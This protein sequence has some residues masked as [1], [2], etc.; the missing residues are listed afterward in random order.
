MLYIVTPLSRVENLESI[1]KSFPYNFKNSEFVQWHVLVDNKIEGKDQKLAI[2]L[3]KLY[4]NQFCLSSTGTSN[5]FVGHA[6]RNE[7]ISEYSDSEFIKNNSDFIDE[8]SDICDW[9]YFLDD[10]TILH[11]KFLLE[12]LQEL[13]DTKH[14]IIFDQE[15]KDGNI[16]LAADINNVKVGHI[17][18]GQYV[19]NL[20]LL[21]EDIQ[22]K[23][24]DYCADGIFIEELFNRV[25]PEQFIVIN[26]TLS[27]YNKLR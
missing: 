7:F 12:I 25:G 23:E 14:A 1:V 26:K 9:I 3:S 10:D 5:A 13:N 16:R 24:D 2:A 22:F 11:P 19:I 15:D 20:S 4:N 6:H 21:P 17:D 18:M 27:T 8:Y